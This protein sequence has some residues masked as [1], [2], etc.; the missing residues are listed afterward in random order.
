VNGSYCFLLLLSPS[1]VQAIFKIETD[2]KVSEYITQLFVNHI[3]EEGS[4]KGAA[5]AVIDSINQELQAK[6][7][8]GHL[9]P[10]ETSLSMVVVPLND[11]IVELLSES[12][13]SIH[14]QSHGDNTVESYVD[15]SEYFVD[16]PEMQDKRN[17]IEAKIAS[18]KQLYKEKR[19]LRP[20]SED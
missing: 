1:L 16:T 15:F 19:T 17:D 4:L 18:I 2:K 5:Q 14:A 13:K 11:E 9:R 20:I 6:I 7:E 10:L 12:E 3:R 8:H